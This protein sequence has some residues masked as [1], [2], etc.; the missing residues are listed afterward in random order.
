MAADHNKTTYNYNKIYLNYGILKVC[1][2][3]P[4][5]QDKLNKPCAFLPGL[6]LAVA[7]LF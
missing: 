2:V 5:N 4:S 6:A 1:P 3:R 7:P